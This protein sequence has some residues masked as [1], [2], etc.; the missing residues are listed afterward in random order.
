[1]KN[2]HKALLWAGAI[3][4]AAVYSNATD[5]SDSA[6]FAITM[7]LVAAAW[8]TLNLRRGRCKKVCV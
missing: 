8:G 5:M 1:M 2:T 7:A 4:G 3:L 6:S